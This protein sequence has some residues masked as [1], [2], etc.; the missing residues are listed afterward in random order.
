MEAIRR[1]STPH[2]VHARSVSIN[3]GADT[4][5][6]FLYTKKPYKFLCLLA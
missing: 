3:Y 6:A 4:E 5:K 1:L 2:P